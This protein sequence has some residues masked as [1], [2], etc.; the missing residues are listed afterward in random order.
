MVDTEAQVVDCSFPWEPLPTPSP[1]ACHRA[2]HRGPFY[3]NL[4]KHFLLSV[5]F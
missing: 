4:L 2:V 3:L 1:G 5:Y